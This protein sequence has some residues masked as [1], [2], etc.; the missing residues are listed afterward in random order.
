MQPIVL[1]ISNKDSKNEPNGFTPGVTLPGVLIAE[2]YDNLG[3]LGDKT[4]PLLNRTIEYI[5]TGKKGNSKAGLESFN[6][7]YNSKLATPT[8]NNM[9]V[10]LKS[11]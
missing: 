2:E 3:V 6:E 1:E 10:N 4:E 8:S 9:Y 5:T 11:N 7:Y